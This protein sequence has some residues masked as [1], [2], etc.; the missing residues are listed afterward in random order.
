[1]DGLE[2]DGRLR[3]VRV[4]AD[5]RGV[6][7]ELSD[8]GVRAMESAEVRLA[9]IVED[10]CDLGDREPLLDAFASVARILDSEVEKRFQV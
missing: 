10:V 3:R 4:E 9:G 7:L 5:R 2:K 1:M 6:R 8:A